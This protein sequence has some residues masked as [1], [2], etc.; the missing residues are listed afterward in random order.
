MYMSLLVLI[1]LSTTLFAFCFL[2]DKITGKLIEINE[3][4]YASEWY[5]YPPKIQM[6]IVP[7]MRQSQ[8]P[9]IVSGCSL[10]ICSLQ[11]FKG[12]SLKRIHSLICYPFIFSSLDAK[13]RRFCIYAFIKNQ[14]IKQSNEKN[15]LCGIIL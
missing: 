11:S 5:T 4:I 10:V 13:L 2:G 1:F 3:S 6:F 7:V 9:F 14:Q 15:I 12:V 8:R